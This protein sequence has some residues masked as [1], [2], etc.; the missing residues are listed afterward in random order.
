MAPRTKTKTKVKARPRVTR[1]QTQGNEGSQVDMRPI[2]GSENLTPLT[3]IHEESRPATPAKS[4]ASKRTERSSASHRTLVENMTRDGE[5]TPTAA[6]LSASHRTSSR[7][8]SSTARRHTNTPTVSVNRDPRERERVLNQQMGLNSSPT[9][10]QSDRSS[11]GDQWSTPVAQLETELKIRNNAEK[12]ARDRAEIAAMFGELNGIVEVMGRN[13]KVL[14]N[15]PA[16]MRERIEHRQG[17]ADRLA[18]VANVREAEFHRTGR[19]AYQRGEFRRIAAD[20]LRDDSTLEWTEDRSDT[21]RGRDW[22]DDQRRW[23]ERQETPSTQSQGNSS[24]RRE[25]D[26][27][28]GR[29]HRVNEPEQSTRR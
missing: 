20:E 11:N 16:R 3:S 1:S 5:R 8:L 19:L 14:K 13:I 6:N 26:R 12:H 29:D 22:E 28:L 10:P 17:I 25:Q 4:S 15:N 23:D 27:S 21:I 24:R 2:S 18:R 7:T 9:G